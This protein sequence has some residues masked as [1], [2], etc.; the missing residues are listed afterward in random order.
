MQSILL[1][2]AMTVLGC[3]GLT[4]ATLA[5]LSLADDGHDLV[6]YNSW[7]GQSFSLSTTA[8]TGK[9][10]AATF[11]LEI[12]IANTKL[13][14]RVVGSVAGTGAPDMSDVYTQLRI[15]TNPTGTTLQPVFFQEDPEITSRLMVQGATYWLVIG[16]TDEDHEQASPAGLIRWHFASTNGQDPDA[17]A[18]WQ[19]GV[20]T[21][22]S[23]TAGS[24][25]SPVA[26]TPY[27]FDV[28]LT[29]APIP[30]PGLAA[31]L[32]PA[33]LFSFRRRRP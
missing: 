10:T 13:V 33:A 5:T 6:T 19:V 30:E 24:N 16:M 4:A 1:P 32:L 21:A 31:L 2:L 29:P 25:W 9:I 15:T 7:K 23:G 20:M 18:G 22:A 17:P 12:V 14:A 26:T 11:R 8:E 3:G 27:L 28:T